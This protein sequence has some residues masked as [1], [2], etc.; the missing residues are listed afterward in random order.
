MPYESKFV[1]QKYFVY[2]TQKKKNWSRSL[3]LVLCEIN[4][5]TV[6]F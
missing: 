3:N 1:R 2:Q 4:K 6:I 5:L